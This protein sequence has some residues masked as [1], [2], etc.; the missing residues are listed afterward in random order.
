MYILV[1]SMFCMAATRLFLTVAAIASLAT[2]TSEITPPHQI[3]L[4][5]SS[6]VLVRAQSCQCLTASWSCSTAKSSMMA[7]WLQ[8]N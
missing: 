1:A 6:S 8:R 2:P 4:Y 5:F 3:L 7:A